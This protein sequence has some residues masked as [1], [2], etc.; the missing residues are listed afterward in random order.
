MRANALEAWKCGVAISL[1]SKATAKCI[2]NIL[3]KRLVGTWIRT[4]R[5]RTFQKT[6]IRML[7]ERIFA[8][9]VNIV[10]K[11][12]DI[13]VAAAHRGYF[14]AR[15]RYFAIWKAF[16]DTKLRSNRQ[17]R[18]VLFR[19]Y[20]LHTK[21]AFERFKAELFYPQRVKARAL[22]RIANHDLQIQMPWEHKY[23]EAARYLQHTFNK[24]RIGVD[25]DWKDARLLRR[26]WSLLA[27]PILKLRRALALR[28]TTLKKISFRA[29]RVRST[30]LLATKYF[31]SSNT[32]RKCFIEWRQH[33]M[34]SKAQANRAVQS[35][36]RMLK[37]KYF[38]ML[39]LVADA[40]FNEKCRCGIIRA[41][42]FAKRCRN[43]WYSHRQKAE[44]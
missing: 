20:T 28:D 21:H 30:K 27:R 39:L 2:R 24:M 17:F 34:F 5:C 33:A 12:R 3:R 15:K 7:L 19:W 10:S 37:K 6:S 25:A 42:F 11:A 44:K 8:S 32:R 29:I 13:K 16:V 22:R 26:A 35:Y 18:N 31:A 36:Q 1:R 40:H 43:G 38:A 14:K 4:V 9:L 23:D 41:R